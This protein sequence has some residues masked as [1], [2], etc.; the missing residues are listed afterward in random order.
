V[1]RDDAAVQGVIFDLDGTL[2]DSYGPIARSLNHAL[3]SAG[4]AELPA[5]QVRR[6]V[7]HGLEALVHEAMDGEGVDEGVRL[8]R[9]KYAE[10]FMDETRLL[11]GVAQTVQALA[12][13]GYRMGVA[14]NKPA[15]FGRP[16]LEHL[17]LAGFFSGIIGPDVMGPPKPH[18]AMV[19]RLLESMQLTTQQ[20]VYV[21]DMPVDVETCRN[22]G[23]PC[24]LVPTGSSSLEE[25]ET[26]GG[27]RLLHRFPQLLD[28]LPGIPPA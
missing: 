24:W 27:Q 28:R 5:D 12:A 4:R 20:V 13:R 8:F 21:G 25:L 15:R 18:P 10:V 26:A 14:S 3:R 2:V 6:M 7:G 17:G 23:I 11:S 22:A 16:L 19:H 1:P 9:E